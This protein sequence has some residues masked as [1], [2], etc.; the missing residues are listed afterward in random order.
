MG[1]KELLNLFFVFVLTSIIMGALMPIILP[2]LGII[3]ILFIGFLIYIKFKAKSI[4]N[5]HVEQ[6]NIYEEPIYYRNH[7]NQNDII[8]VEYTEHRE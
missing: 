1:F 3:I 2:I 8:D 7:V 5:I 6:E 4:S